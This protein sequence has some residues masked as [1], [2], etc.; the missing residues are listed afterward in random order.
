MLNVMLSELM[1]WNMDVEIPTYVRC[2]NSDAVYQVGSANTAASEKLL[3]G[4]LESN[5]EELDQNNWLSVG[6]TPGDMNTSDGLTK[7]LSSGNLRNLLASNIFRIITPQSH[8]IH[9]AG[10]NNSADTAGFPIR[11]LD[12]YNKMVKLSRCIV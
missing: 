11:I 5:S 12:M 4:F 1:S 9:C 6:F 10:A 7:I 8:A 3:K 2:D